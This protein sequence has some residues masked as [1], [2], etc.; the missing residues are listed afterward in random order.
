MQQ[1]RFEITRDAKG[2]ML[3]MNAEHNVGLFTDLASQARQRRAN[4]PQAGKK[5]A[6]QGAGPVQLTDLT[7]V[8]RAFAGTAK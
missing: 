3:A 1:G 5:L 4:L 7:Q 8:V 6:G 2:N